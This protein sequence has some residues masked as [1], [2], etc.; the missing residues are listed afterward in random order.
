MGVRLLCV[1]RA[2]KLLLRASVSA[3]DAETYMSFPSN[4]GI[5]SLARE[6]CCGITLRMTSAK[7]LSRYKIIAVQDAVRWLS[8]ARVF[9]RS[10]MARACLSVSRWC[11]GGRRGRRAATRWADSS[12]IVV[13]RSGDAGARLQRGGSGVSVADAMMLG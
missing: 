7:E 2:R 4:L 13:Y 3:R 5:Y 9:G 8:D 1:V 11:L 12:V 10:S 6:F